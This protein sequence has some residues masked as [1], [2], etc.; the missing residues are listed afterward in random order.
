[1]KM[2]M[3]DLIPWGRESRNPSLW[4]PSRFEGS[5]TP[6]LYRGSEGDPFLSL[7]REMN[8]LFDD[9]LRG[10]DLPAMGQRTAAGWPMV[11]ATETDN[12]VRVCAELPGMQ[13]KDVEVL[14]EDGVLTLR[15]ERKSE[16]DDKDRGYSERYYGRFERRIGLPTAVQ[17]DQVSATFKDGVLTV[18]LPKAPEAI[19]QARR[20]PISGGE[21]TKH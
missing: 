19:D 8:R 3:R 7:H 13:D 12:E 11:E 5:R 14:L 15:G 9:V 6:S 10:F 2:A 1:M 18:T 17:E 16:T 4:S 21:A 20:I